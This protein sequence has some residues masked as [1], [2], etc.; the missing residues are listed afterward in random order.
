MKQFLYTEKSYMQN[1][2]SVAMYY[3]FFTNKKSWK[4]NSYIVIIQ[5]ECLS[6]LHTIIYTRWIF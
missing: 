6:I 4:K 1:L 3:I 5:I 2:Y